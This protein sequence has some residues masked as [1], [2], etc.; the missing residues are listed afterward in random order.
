MAGICAG[1]N[2]LI[3]SRVKQGMKI[4]DHIGSMLLVVFDTCVV[5]FTLLCDVL[6]MR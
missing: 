6:F 1:P 4:H 2:Q 5:I 3:L